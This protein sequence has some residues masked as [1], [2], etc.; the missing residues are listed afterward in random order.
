MIEPYIRKII[1]VDQ[2][3]LDDLKC[4]SITDYLEFSDPG[5]DTHIVT[6]PL[7]A[8]EDIDA[9]I[10][11]VDPSAIRPGNIVVKPGY[12]DQFVSLD[13]FAEDMVYRKYGL[14]VHFCI[15]L[16]AK[17]VSISSIEDVGLEANETDSVGGGVSGSIPGGKVEANAKFKQSNLTE[18]FRKSIMK[19]NTEAQGGEPNLEVAEKLMN[20]YGLHRDSLFNDLLNMCIVSTNQLRKH[21]ISLDFSTDVKRV[22][23]SSIQA[24]IKMM[25]KLYQGQADFEKTR[26]SLAKNNSATKLTVVVEF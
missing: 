5:I 22:F 23:D 13:N 12:T 4:T 10:Q 14:F 26:K 20:R 15:A 9:L 11:Y 6:L 17:K 24:K 18:D 8:P 2:N 21:E 3:F 7:Q 19:L 25:N 1:I 16:G